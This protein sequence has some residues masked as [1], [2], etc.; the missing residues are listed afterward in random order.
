MGHRSRA[1]CMGLILML[2]LVAAQ[3]TYAGD[4]A[5]SGLIAFGDSV[6]DPG[7]VYALTGQESVAPYEP[8]PTFPYA[9]G[10]HHFSNGKTYVERRACHCG[11]MCLTIRMRNPT[12]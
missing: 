1:L 10:G 11:L 3:S 9:I 6:S 12:T 7:N 8:V 4:T 5:Y 2:L